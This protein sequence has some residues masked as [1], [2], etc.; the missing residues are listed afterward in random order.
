MRTFFAALA[1]AVAGSAVIVAVAVAVPDP[2]SHAT[3]ASQMPM[4]GSMGS[5]MNAPVSA[6][7]TRKLMI[8]HVQNGCHVWSDG[9]QTASTMRMHLV[10]GQHLAITD[11][12][13]DAHQMMQLAG[14]AHMRMGGPMM[15]NQHMTLT[16]QKAGVYR[17]RTKTVEMPGAMEV[18][19]TGP[20]NQLRLVVTVR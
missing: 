2:S 4:G 15:M 7:P 5:M 1:G 19:T 13:V 9:K 11:M 16:F 14:P 17:F 3:G 10:R 12:D 20:D 18:E 8:Q 6:A